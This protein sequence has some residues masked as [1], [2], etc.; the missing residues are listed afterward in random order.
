[1]A[2]AATLTSDQTL[3]AQ[4]AG[5]A[6]ANRL[7]VT[8]GLAL[9]SLIAATPAAGVAETRQGTFFVNVGPQLTVQQFRQAIAT[10]SLSGLSTNGDVKLNSWQ[11]TGVEAGFDEEA[12]RVRVEF[13]ALV[14]VDSAAAGSETTVFGVGIQVTILAAI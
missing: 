5:P 2:T 13:D 6:G 14:S 8:T 12:G 11:I 7:F 9:F 10:A 1:M 3:E 4:V